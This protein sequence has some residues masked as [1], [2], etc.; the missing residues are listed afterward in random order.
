MKP[1]EKT[2]GTV[3]VASG[4]A[5]ELLELCKG[6]FDGVSLAVAGGVVTMLGR[7]VGYVTGLSLGRNHG[8]G[9]AH[10]QM[11]TQGAGVIATVGDQ[12]AGTQVGQQLL[13]GCL[14]VDLSGREQG[15]AKRIGE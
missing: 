4:K 13:C 10:G 1:S 6:A 8:L 2:V 3:I 12:A 7:G 9:A 5:S 15:A 14:V 11:G